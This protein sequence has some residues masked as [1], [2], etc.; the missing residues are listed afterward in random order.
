MITDWQRQVEE[1]IA[2]HLRGIRSHLPEVEKKR[3]LEAGGELHVFAA[4][5][6]R[7]ITELEKGHLNLARPKTGDAP[8]MSRAKL[9]LW[10]A[11]ERAAHNPNQKALARSLAERVRHWEARSRELLGGAPPPSVPNDVDPAPPIP[12]PPARIASKIPEA[13]RAAVAPTPAP[14][15]A[16][17][18]APL[19]MTPAP[20]PTPAAAPA[21][22]AAKAPAPAPVPV[23]AP[24]AAAPAKPEA[25]GDP[26]KP[27][28]K[29]KEKGKK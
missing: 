14:R 23:P 27:K 10:R 12:P 29:K 13:P 11:A 24:A 16:A 22:A 8:W 9:H 4:W 1:T 5:A 17:E 21:P 15:A 26:E 20:A 2:H 3:R 6:K 25:A 18:Q 7:R 28:A 19:P